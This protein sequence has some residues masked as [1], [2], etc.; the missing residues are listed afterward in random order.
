MVLV[1]LALFLGSLF[2]LVKSAEYCTMRSSSLARFLHI[3][4]FVVSFFVVALIST[5]PEA[6]VSILSAIE[7]MPQ[8]GLGT[9]FGSNVA[10]LTLVFGIVALLSNKGVHVKSEILKEDFL[11]LFLLMI[12]VLLGFD[13][14]YSRVD[15]FIMV[16]CGLFFF[17][18]LSIESHIFKKQYNGIKSK[19]FF[20]DLALLMLGLVV[21]LVSAYYT[22]E[23]G[24]DFANDVHI[25]PVLVGLT[26]ISIGSCLPELLFS[27]KAVKSNHEALALGDIL[28]TVITD[29]TIIFGIVCL[30]SPFS[31]N[32]I[33]VYIT[34]SAMFLAG[35]LVIIFITSGKILT[36][37]EGAYLLFF[38]IIYLI[39]EFIASK[40]F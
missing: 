31:F 28:G 27:I 40:G 29:A 26:V 25:P 20:K 17:F 6:T 10:D 14:E 15:G 16:L 34:G 30:I 2:V 22:L 13:G 11:Y 39:V 19:E 3:S 37:K 7:G 12:P 21:L 33:L 36:K 35:I 1:N 32:P 5:F 8:F 18:T 38:Y 24:V 4:E 9:L 23:F